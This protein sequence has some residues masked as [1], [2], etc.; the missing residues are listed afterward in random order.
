VFDGAG[1]GTLEV[2]GRKVEIVSIAINGKAVEFRAGEKD[3]AVFAGTMEGDMLSGTYHDSKQTLSFNMEREPD[4]KPPGDRVEAW[5]QDLEYAKRK[6]L[7]LD[8][9][10]TPETRAAYDAALIK[11]ISQV[12]NLRDDQLIVNLARAVALADNGHTRL[13]LLRN[14]TDLRRY[15]VRVWWF[16]DGP[17]VIRAPAEKSA[18]LGCRVLAVRVHQRRHCVSCS[19]H[20]MQVPPRGIDYMASYLI[21]SPEILA[22]VGVLK[23]PGVSQWKLLCSNGTKQSRWNRCRLNAKRVRSKLGG[24]FC[25]ANRRV[26]RECWVYSFKVCRCT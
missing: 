19:R 7:K 17:Y 13:Y 23:E 4:L 3:P 20:S 5:R 9:S 2:L 18:M 26:P 11:L 12:S 25:R 22:G 10:F 6:L 8:K 14:R 16:R 1:K 24:I 15:P 21:T